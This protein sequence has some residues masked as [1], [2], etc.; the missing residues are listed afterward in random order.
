MRTRQLTRIAN[1]VLLTG[2]LAI[3]AS[4]SSPADAPPAATPS[5]SAGATLPAGA[6]VQRSDAVSQKTQA[7]SPPAGAQTDTVAGEGPTAIGTANQDLD[8]DSAWVEEIDVDGDGDIESAQ[9]LWDDEDK[10]LFISKAGPFTCLNGDQ[11]DGT[12]LMA[13]FAEGNARSRPSGS[14]WWVAGLDAGEC[15]VKDEGIYGCRFGADGLATECGSITVDEATDDV[16]I[17]RIQ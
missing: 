14:G 10:V 17:T 13:I 3:A 9:L 5:S 11:G 1:A 4:C 7:P 8:S 6:K 12:L 2:G 15:A 16:T